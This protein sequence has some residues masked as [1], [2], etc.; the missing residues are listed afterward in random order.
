MYNTLNH[1]LVNQVNESPVISHFKFEE[2]C[3]VGQLQRNKY[4]S[5][6]WV[7]EGQGKVKTGF[8]EFDF[9]EN[10]L[11]TFAPFQP[12]L[13]SS[14]NPIK[15]IVI[16]FH[17][18]FIFADQP[19]KEKAFKTV[20]YNSVTQPPFVQINN[21]SITVFDM[22]CEKIEGEIQ[23]TLMAQHDLLGAYL[24][25]LLINSFR[26]KLEQ[27]QVEGNNDTVVKEPYILQKLINAIE[28]NFKAKH[29]PSDYAAML[30]VT[31]KTLGKVSKA[32]YNKSISSIINERIITEAKRELYLTKKAIKEIAY[33]LGYEDEYYFSRFF[34][35]NTQVSPQKYREMI[36]YARA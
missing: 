9:R 2:N 3:F 12:Y 5:L 7:K 23:D 24:R 20:L 28:E 26:L 1:S 36:W 6:I 27:Q 11:F 22:L 33:E 30:Y 29:S 34:K 32:Y 8:S 35:I 10:S 13:I 14:E 17:A 31:A 18:E 19:E 4:F 15:G 16:N 21:S 25:I